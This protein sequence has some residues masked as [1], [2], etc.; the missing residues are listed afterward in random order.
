MGPSRPST[1]YMSK[2]PWV[3][4]AAAVTVVALFRPRLRRRIMAKARRIGKN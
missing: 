2:L 1:S 4:L 3:A